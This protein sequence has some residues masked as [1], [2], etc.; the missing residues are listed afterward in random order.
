MLQKFSIQS[1]LFAQALGLSLLAAAAFV[2]SHGIAAIKGEPGITFSG[3]Y[4]A[5][6]HAQTSRDTLNAALFLGAAAKMVPDNIELLRRA[7]V[8]ALSEGDIAGGIGFLQ[9]IEK[10][11]GDAPLS[12]IVHAAQLIKSG[13]YGDVG[14]YFKTD[15]KKLEG[16]NAY[17]GPI[18]NAW[19]LAGE[20]KFDQAIKAL[21]K[22]KEK[23]GSLAFSELHLGLIND[24]GGKGEAAEINYNAVVKE[25]GMSL[26]LAQHFGG[27]LERSGKPTEALEIYAQYD[28]IDEAYGTLAAAEKRIKSGIKPAPEINTP[29]R[30]AAEAMFGLASSLSVQGATESAMVLAQLALYLRPDFPAAITVVGNILES[31]QR[32]DDANSIYKK[33]PQSSI[34]YE[35]TKLRIAVNLE[36]LKQIDDAIKMLKEISAANKSNSS[37]LVELGD[38]LRRAERFSEAATAYSQALGRINKI[39]KRHWGIFYSRGISFER[40]DKWKKAENDFLTALKMDPDQP[41]VLN[42]LGYSWIEKKINLEKAVSMIQKAVDLRPRDGYIVDSLGWGL[43]QLGDFATAVKKLERAVLLRPEDPIINDHLG[44]ALWRVGR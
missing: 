38:I 19:A 20:K 23:T 1:I 12:D 6:R 27:M 5:G 14:K 26:R 32:F 41:F 15:G 24:M 11:G 43:Y 2:P 21:A 33:I 34:M 10:L 8:L 22:D 3:N 17:V 40:S 16:I 13:N 36:R 44:D 28:A 9:R 39:D 37:A 18:L 30:G 25:S 29:A 35:Q 31:Y 42:Y 7:Y 4:L